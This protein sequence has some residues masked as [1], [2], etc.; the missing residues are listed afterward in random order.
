MMLPLKRTYL[1]IVDDGMFIRCEN[2][3][4]LHVSLPYASM[5]PDLDKERDNMVKF[6]HRLPDSKIVR[7]NIEVSEL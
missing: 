2:D 7:L 1:A 5:W 3:K 4:L 6:H